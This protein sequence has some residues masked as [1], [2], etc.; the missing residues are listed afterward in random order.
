[1]PSVAYG[2]Y[3]AEVFSTILCDYITFRPMRKIV[4]TALANKVGVLATMTLM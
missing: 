4:K 3:N 1:M 2:K